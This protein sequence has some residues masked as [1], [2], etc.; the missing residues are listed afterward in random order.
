MQCPK[1]G[2]ENPDNAEFC[3]KCGAQLKIEQDMKKYRKRVL[4]F[5]Y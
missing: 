4:F 1:C 5:Q 3:N 2:N